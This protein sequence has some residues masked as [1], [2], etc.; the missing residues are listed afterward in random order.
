MSIWFIFLFLCLRRRLAAEGILF[1]GYPPGRDR[2][3]KVC[4][5]DFS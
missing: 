4:E 3:L 1:S 2:I 5:H